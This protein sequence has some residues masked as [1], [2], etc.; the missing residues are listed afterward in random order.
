MGVFNPGSGT[1]GV[2]ARAQRLDVLLGILAFFTAM[3][4]IQTV[5]LELRG[6]SA[7]GSALVL[8]V[9]VVGTWL[10]WRARRNTG[11]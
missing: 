7:L 8:F 4:A 11:V 5:V 3:A 6:D 10:T 1:G 9:L 2:R